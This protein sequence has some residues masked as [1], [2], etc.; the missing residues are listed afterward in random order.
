MK[1]TVRFLILAFPFMLPGNSFAQSKTPGG[2]E[3][4]LTQKELV[5]SVEKVESLIAKCMHKQGF[6]YVPSD[7]KTVRRGMVTEKSQ[8]GMSEDEFVEQFGFGIS[9]RYTGQPPQLAEG[10]NPARV[11]L[12]KRNVEIF[13]K[14]SRADQA[15][16]NRALLGN[17]LNATFAMSLEAEDF[18]RCGGCTL[19][20]IKQVFKPEQIT[21]TYYNP[22]DA[23]VNKDPRMKAALRTYSEKMRSAGFEYNHPD[24]VE[25][26]VRKRLDAILG[27][28][29]PLVEKLSPEQQAALKKL[30]EYERR[31]AKANMKLEE[32]VFDPVEARILKEMYAR[33]I[34]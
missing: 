12:G 30:Q 4:G 18:S 17:N 34:E 15:A 1:K 2:E 3:F 32:E 13:K 25:G 23:L 14:L 21:V 26:D 27:G 8:P 6:D 10:Y 19:E 31:V 9:T 5:Q 7:F 33:K 28:E 11:S 16:Y 29:T 22:K 24:E 20:A